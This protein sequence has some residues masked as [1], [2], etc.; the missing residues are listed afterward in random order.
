MTGAPKR[1]TTE[2]IDELEGAARGVYS[3]AIGWFGLG[4]ACD[5][6]VAIRT[7]VL[8]GE[9]ATVGAGGAIVLDSDPEREYEEMLLK[10]AAPLRA[11]DA[12]LDPAPISLADQRRRAGVSPPA[13]VPDLTS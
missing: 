2:I 8:D 12:G 3:G 4:G 10:A 1:R 11:I 9:E 6:S 5:L 13:S 7:I